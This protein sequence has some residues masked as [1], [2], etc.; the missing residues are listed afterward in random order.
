MKD[1]F[2]LIA[3]KEI[4]SQLEWIQAKAIQHYHDDPEA[5]DTIDH[6]A[7]VAGM[8]ASVTE[9]YI[10][11]DYIETGNPQN[12]IRAKLST[13]YD[14]VKSYNDEKNKQKNPNAITWEL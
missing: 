10:E 8:F 12:Y 4:R 6:L 14:N 3:I 2:D 5:F 7:R 11:N 13:A 9:Q 1:K